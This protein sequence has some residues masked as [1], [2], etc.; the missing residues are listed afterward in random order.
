[1]VLDYWRL[2]QHFVWEWDWFLLEAEQQLPD[3]VEDERWRIER[4]E[5]GRMVETL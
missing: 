3:L 1:M 5:A 4:V 2:E